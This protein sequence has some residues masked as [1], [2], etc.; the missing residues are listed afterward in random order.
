MNFK[1]WPCSML[2][3]TLSSPNTP[4]RHAGQ[5]TLQ[6]FHLQCGA[7]MPPCSHH[8]LALPPADRQSLETDLI[9]PPRKICTVQS[10]NLTPIR[11]SSMQYWQPSELET[12]CKRFYRNVTS[13]TAIQHYKITDTF[14]EPCIKIEHR[15]MLGKYNAN[16]THIDLHVQVTLRSLYNKGIAS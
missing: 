9:F 13:Y 3:F 4:Q 11:V 6:T 7:M 10:T 5:L 8:P 15:V 12:I 16:T 2:Q 1:L 14:E